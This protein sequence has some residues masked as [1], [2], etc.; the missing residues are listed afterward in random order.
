LNA[1]LLRLGGG[2]PGADTGRGK[3]HLN[4]HYFRPFSTQEQGKRSPAEGAVDIKM[5]K[6]KGEEIRVKKAYRERTEVL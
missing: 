2:K 1:F 5:E 3:E 6:E 4:D